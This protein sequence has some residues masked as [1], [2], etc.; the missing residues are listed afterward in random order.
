MRGTGEINELV[1]IVLYCVVWLDGL[2]LDWKFGLGSALDF[3]GE[4]G[5]GM[6]YMTSIY[7]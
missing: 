7:I 4:G 2:N 3:F 6:V 1:C 5:G